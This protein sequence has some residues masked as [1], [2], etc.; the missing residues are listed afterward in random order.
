[1]NN[2]FFSP[3]FK[4]FIEFICIFVHRNKITFNELLD[5]ASSTTQFPSNSGVGTL[6]DSK[7]TMVCKNLKAGSEQEQVDGMFW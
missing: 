6:F 3:S 4:P 2:I 7:A 1:M 5:W